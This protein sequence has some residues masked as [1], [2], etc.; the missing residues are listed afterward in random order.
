MEGTHLNCFPRAPKHCWCNSIRRGMGSR[1][2]APSRSPAA[3]QKQRSLVQH[4]EPRYPS[5]PLLQCGTRRRKVKNKMAQYINIDFNIPLEIALKYSTP[6]PVKSKS[7][8]PLAMF[9]CT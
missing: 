4:T 6:L 9:T 2:G 7:G 5:V 3:S 1:Y 8:S